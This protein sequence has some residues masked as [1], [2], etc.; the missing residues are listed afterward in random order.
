[1]IGAEEFVVRFVAAEDSRRQRMID[2]QKFSACR[3]ENAIARITRN[4]GGDLS[5]QRRLFV[6]RGFYFRNVFEVEELGVFE[7]VAE[8]R[9]GQLAKLALG[10]N[11]SGETIDAEGPAG[12]VILAVVDQA[13]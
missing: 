8:T 5:E 3:I 2:A 1:M 9:G 13:T 6:T 10:L 12:P 4:T 7:A 11:I